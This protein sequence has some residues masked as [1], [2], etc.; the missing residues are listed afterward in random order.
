M[1]ANFIDLTWKYLQYTYILKFE[2]PCMYAFGLTMHLLEEF[3]GVF[4]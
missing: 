4:L 1:N 2:Y 3:F